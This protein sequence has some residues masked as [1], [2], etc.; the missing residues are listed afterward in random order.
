MSLFVSSPTFKRLID[1]E[2]ENT[3]QLWKSVV[4]TWYDPFWNGIK[5]WDTAPSIWFPSKYHWYT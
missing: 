4:E 5:N 2:S 1:I 3:S